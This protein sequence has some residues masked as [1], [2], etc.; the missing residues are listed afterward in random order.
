MNRTN[1]RIAEESKRKFVG[2]LLELMKVYPYTDIT[3]TQL[4]QEAELSRKTFYRL[5]N[6]KDDVLKLLF[7]GLYYECFTQIKG[8]NIRRYWDL[9]QLYFDFWESRKD[10]LL[11]LSRN[12]LLPRLFEYVYRNAQPI[13]TAVRTEET[14]QSFAPT[15]PYL[16]AYSVG[17]MHS[18]LMK[19]AESGMTTPSTALIQQLKAG[20][21][22]PDL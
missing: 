9:V 22:S 4:S 14:T 15:L 11:L 17:G 19:W 8:Q 10:I 18:M 3:V 1:G 16:L 5:F 12:D 2:A 13:F 20:F 21:Q 7:D 6:D